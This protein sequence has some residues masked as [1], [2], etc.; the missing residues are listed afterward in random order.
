[1]SSDETKKPPKTFVA[2]KVPLL[3][4]SERIAFINLIETTKVPQNAILVLM[5]AV[6][7]LY[8]NIP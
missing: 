7:N 2:T 6:T 5:D 1:M 3:K 4:T 8:T